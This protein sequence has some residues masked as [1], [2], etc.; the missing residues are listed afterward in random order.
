MPN[1]KAKKAAPKR[2]HNDGVQ[3]VSKIEDP[4]QTPV[5][6]DPSGRE[7]D[8][9]GRFTPED[10][11]PASKPKGKASATPTKKTEQGS[12]AI[13]SPLARLI[14]EIEVRLRELRSIA[15]E[16]SGRETDAAPKSK[17]ARSRSVGKPEASSQG[18]ITKNADGLMED[19]H[20]RAS[21]V[22]D[23]EIGMDEG[24]H[25]VDEM[26]GGYLHGASET[27]DSRSDMM[28]INIPS[29]SEHVPEMPELED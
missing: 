18:R 26:A 29:T 14:S 28:G 19:H 4:N 6:T 15:G 22:R 27:S 16:H 12:T 11:H 24:P 25:N 9:L 3:G 21:S 7:H 5:E 8:E 20:S 10:E 17:P 13:D 1:S 2:E 23:V